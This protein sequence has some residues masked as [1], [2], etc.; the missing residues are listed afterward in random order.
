MNAPPK[1]ARTASLFRANR[2]Q[3]VRIPRDLEFPADVK[4][5]YVIRVGKR[6]EV[7]PVGALWDGFFDRPPNPDFPGREQP[8]AQER[9][10]GY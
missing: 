8:P 1:L 4:E 9:D 6:L 7:I 3:A 10:F 5:V 2:N